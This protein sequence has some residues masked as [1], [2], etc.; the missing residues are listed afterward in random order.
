MTSTG[1]SLSEGSSFPADAKVRRA[2]SCPEMKKSVSVLSAGDRLPLDENEEDETHLVPMARIECLDSD[3]GTS[4][5]DQLSLTVNGHSSGI[6]LTVIKHYFF[7][8]TF[9]FFYIIFLHILV[10]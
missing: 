3:G 6:S 4:K 5:S 10:S 7:F 9:N 1:S 8:V 2:I